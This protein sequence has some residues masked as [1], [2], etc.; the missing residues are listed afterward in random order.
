MKS[1]NEFYTELDELK[2]TNPDGV[3]KYLVDTFNDHQQCCGRH[4]DI[5]MA[6]RSELAE[7]CKAKGINY[8]QKIYPGYHEWR[9]WRAAFHDYAQLVFKN[10]YAS[11]AAPNS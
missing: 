6:C 9:V 8:I 4:N 10:R 7:Y 5:D 1:L 3:H 11:A 2:K